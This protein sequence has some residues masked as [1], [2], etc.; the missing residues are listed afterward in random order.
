MSMTTRAERRARKREK[1]KAK[2][3]ERKA[4]LLE[5]LP[6][7]FLWCRSL[8]AEAEAY[9]EKAIRAGRPIPHDNGALWSY[10][11]LLDRSGICLNIIARRV[12]CTEEELAMF[13]PAINPAL[14]AMTPASV[15][16][17]YKRAK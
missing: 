9:A 10:L 8:D 2:E 5:H 7:T 13:W 4:E 3:E 16:N 14:A 6:D 17:R 12:G 15:H 11:C 1:R